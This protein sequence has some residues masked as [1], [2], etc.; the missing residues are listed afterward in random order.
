MKD[1]IVLKMDSGTILDALNVRSIPKLRLVRPRLL[2]VLESFEHKVRPLRAQMECHVA[3]SRILSAARDTLLP[4][5]I[6]GEL[7]IS[8]K[9]KIPAGVDA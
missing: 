9:K 8:D 7:R 4:K 3:E 1:E 6:S 5:L 2:G